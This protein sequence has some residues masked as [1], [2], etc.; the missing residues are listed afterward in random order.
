ME[1]QIEAAKAAGASGVAIGVLRS[2]ARI[3]VE[4]SR[5]LAELARPMKVTFHRA[6]DETRDQ[7]EALEDVIL[8]GADTLLTSGGAADVLTGAETIARLRIQAAGRLEVMA[9]GGVRLGN[10]AELVRRSGVHCVHGSLTRPAGS[11]GHTNGV[12]PLEEDIR[13]ALRVLRQACG[14][15]AA[16]SVRS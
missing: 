6:F 11:N 3:D 5:A 13:E 8:T 10:L 9:G 14:E 1:R 7:T 15:P 2:D 4:R 16:I 12:A